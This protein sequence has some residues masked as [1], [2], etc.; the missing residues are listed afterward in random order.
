MNYTKETDF[1]NNIAPGVIKFVREIRQKEM[2]IVQ[3]KGDSSDYAT[4]VDVDTE[5]YIV[6][7]LSKLFPN[8]QILAEEGYSDTSISHG[9]MWLI[10]PICG[11]SNLGK[12]INNFCTNIALVIN[13]QVVA[14]CVIDHSE[15]EYIWSPGEGKLFINNKLYTP[16][17]LDIGQKIDVDFGAVRKTDKST[18]QRYYKFLFRIFDETDFDLISLNTSLGFAYTAIGKVDGFLNVIN[19]PWD[20][21]ASSFLIQQAGGVITGIDG[22]E[23]TLDSVGAI[24]ANTPE[25]HKKLVDLFLQ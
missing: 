21:A 10:D 12:G 23:W 4:H 7:E 13:K 1:F 2:T 18:R 17:S 19:H 16:T 14:A 11:T 20:I 3:Q 24:A 8:D 6:A 25:L 5:D 15:G 9:R 22:K